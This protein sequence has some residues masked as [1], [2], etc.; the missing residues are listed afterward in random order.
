MIAI[1]G[2]ELVVAEKQAAEELAEAEE[3]MLT[4]DKPKI[5]V[6]TMEVKYQK[7]N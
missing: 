6:G 2:E 4:D 3:A 7:V 1:L 5:M